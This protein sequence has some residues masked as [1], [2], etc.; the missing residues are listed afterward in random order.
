[1]PAEVLVQLLHILPVLLLMCGAL[2]ALLAGLL[3]PHLAARRAAAVLLGAA[4]LALA[5]TLALPPASSVRVL[6]LLT[7]DAFTAYLWRL[8]LGTLALLVPLSATYVRRHLR[9]PGLFYA[10]LGLLACGALLATATSDTLMLLLALELV[11]ISGC[12]L[13]GFG[14][15]G[16]VSMVALA[17]YVAYG[18]VLT[19]VLALSLAW[20]YG[21]TG[22]TDYGLA[23]QALAGWE[24]TSALAPLLVLLL[25][26]LAFKLGAAPFNPWLP[27]LLEAAQPATAALAILPRI[28]GMGAL[29]RLTVVL[30]PETLGLG[31]VWRWPLLTLLALMS[32]TVGNIAGLRQSGISRLLAY[33][34]I[35]QTG[36]LL[37]ALVVMGERGLGALLLALTA[38]VLAEVGTF[39]AITGLA[40]SAPAKSL[41]DLHGL[42]RRAPLLAGVLL[43]SALSLFGLPG[44]GG[45]VGRLW[46][47]VATF[48]GG[49]LW[50]LG[51][52][53]ANSVLSGAVYWRLVQAPATRPQQPAHPLLMPWA[54][55]MAMLVAGMG[56]LGLGF[57]PGPVVRWAEAAARALFAFG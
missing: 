22:T 33:G 24:S 32:M 44:T 46:L 56:V 45:F 43:L 49:H 20:L 10:S 5:A 28:A 13:A 23:S 48:E 4:L 21:V 11:G 3:P 31:Q 54:S 53:A 38:T 50:L 52:V 42:L 2:L 27:E 6:G 39:A 47:F 30:L 8:L 26:G 57:V 55:Q 9:E 37:I 40:L 1:M 25:A 19:A 14:R 17:R 7:Y 34:G 18:V 12:V 41:T 29:A 35:S 15:E 16:R 36:Y 51:A